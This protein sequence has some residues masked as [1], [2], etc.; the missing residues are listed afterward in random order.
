MLSEAAKI[1]PISKAIL[2]VGIAVFA[3]GVFLIG[4]RT[5]RRGSQQVVDEKVRELHDKD[6]RIRSLETELNQARTELSNHS[7]VVAELKTALE[8]S[9]KEL[10]LTRERLVAAN[11]EVDRLSITRA[12]SAPR[13][14]ARPVDL[15]PAPTIR[16][17]AEHGIYETIRVTAVHETPSGSS[18][19]V[20][21]VAKGTR[22][23]VV[24]SVGDWLEVR[25]K[26]GNPPG[27]VRRDDA[28]FVGRAN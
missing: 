10:T 12:Q 5:E 18:P 16:R 3:L 21:Q 14:A 6:Q 25:S 4:E 17:A 2:V 26:R 15:P 28:L 7:G 27:F 8:A 13:T 24:G 22:L 19:V 1:P 9:K 20:S 11:R 23:T